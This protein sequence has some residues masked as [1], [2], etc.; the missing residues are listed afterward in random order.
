MRRRRSHFNP[1]TILGI[2]QDAS[3]AE[4]ERA[5]RQKLIEAQYSTSISVKHVE[6]AYLVL[7]DPDDRRRLD[8]KLSDVSFKQ[9]FSTGKTDFKVNSEPHPKERKRQRRMALLAGVLLAVL[10]FSSYFFVLRGGEICPL[11]HR[12]SVVETGRTGSRVTLS[13]TRKS[14]DFSFEYDR[15]V[16]LAHDPDED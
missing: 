2:Q 12:K 7:V 11:C 15:A 4:I 3:T 6:A 5:Y 1:Y 14:C 10:A 8:K 9:E 13:C 16:D